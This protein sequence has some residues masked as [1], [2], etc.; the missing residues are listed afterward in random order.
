MKSA[1]IPRGVYF[2]VFSDGTEKDLTAGTSK[3]YTSDVSDITT[4]SKKITGYLIQSSTI[5]LDYYTRVENTFH[6]YSTAS[7]GKKVLKK[8]S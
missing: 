4:F 7:H 8:Y 3:T 6:V 1:R 2:T 5:P